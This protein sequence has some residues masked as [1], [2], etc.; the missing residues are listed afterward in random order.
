MHKS[1]TI[2]PNVISLYNI[3]RNSPDQVEML[4]D[5]LFPK[6]GLAG[7]IGETDVGKT[8][9][10]MQLA[11]ENAYGR[12]TFLGKKLN[13]T[14]KRSLYISTED[15]I[16][17]L[18]PRFKLMIRSLGLDV[19]SN[20]AQRMGVANLY[21]DIPE[22]VSDTLDKA[23]SDIVII[24]SFSDL[25]QY[26]G[27]S[28]AEVRNILKPLGQI[29]SHHQ[30]LIIIL[31]HVRKSGAD[32]P[33]KHDTLGSSAFEAKMRLM[34]SLMAGD[35]PDEVKLRIAKGN[36]LPKEVKSRELILEFKDL[37]FRV[38][39]QQTIQPSLQVIRQIKSDDAVKKAVSELG[40]K[41]QK[42]DLLAKAKEFGYEFGN[43]KFYNDVDPYLV[44]NV[45]LK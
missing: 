22:I 40:V 8:S 30:C 41:A 32:M 14:H 15:D 31:H 5:N 35:R 19:K 29:A 45:K 27:N 4:V 6:V 1:E 16:F 23:P 3:V 10:L 37:A 43:S 28:A 21:E 42:K 38:K 12:E 11:I 25:L 9:F 26:D 17:N 7:L 18:G 20:L 36:Y 2:N 24:D 34:I 44:E 33:G 13:S 39:E